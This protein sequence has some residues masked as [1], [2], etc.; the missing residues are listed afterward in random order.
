MVNPALLAVAFLL[1][2]TTGSAQIVRLVGSANQ[3]AGRL[4]VYYNDTWGTVCDDIF[5]S[6]AARVVCY[7]LGY[8]YVGEFVGN[9]Y[10]RGSGPIWLDN[11][12]CR[13]TETSIVNCPRNGWGIHNC[14]HGEDVSVSCT[15][16]R[17]AG[18]STQAGRL[19]VA[20]HNGTWG[21]VCDDG[22]TDEAAAVA[23][24]MLG[25]GYGGQFV[26]NRYG[27]GSGII[28][29]DDVQCTGTETSIA[30]CRHGGWGR[31]D[32]SHYEDV[33]VSC[34]TVRLTSGQEG[35]LEVYYNRTWGTVCDNGFTDA[36]A[37]VVCNMLGY[38]RIGRFI[39]N[40]YGAGY[41]RRI[42]LDN[43]RCSG[44]ETNIASCQHRGWGSYSCQHHQDVSVSCYDEVRLVGD[45]GSKGR[46][47][48][49]HNGAWGTV[50]DTGFTDTAAR[51]VCYSLGYGYT[52]RFLGNLY[53][54]GSGR[55]WL[56]NV[57]CYG[58]YSHILR[59]QHS[60]WGHHN[61][62]HSND[63]SV[64]CIA[65]ST[66]AVALVGGGSPRVGR[67][68]VF[69]G[70]QWG[71]VCDQGFTDAAARVVC[72]SLGFGYVGR[73]VDINIYGM[74]DGL[75]WLNNINCIGTEQYIGACSHRDPREG[76]LEVF[77]NGTW[78]SVCRD[79]FSDA[80]AKVVCNMLGFG[81]IGRPSSSY[82]SGGNGPTWLR[83]V[84]C[85]GTE[86][87]ISECRFEGWGVQNCY[88]TRQAVSCL[89][90]DAVALFGGGSPREGRL[91]VYHNGTWE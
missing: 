61:C 80:A 21:T 58:H 43:V 70:N 28:W 2:S 76:C 26:G 62:S 67:L 77:Y 59:C 75:I 19:E 78:G 40:R 7:M 37:R 41:G 39:G 38:Q 85:S 3:R 30:H 54:A 35:R 24:Y 45:S 83:S 90:D 71:T 14:V 89:P 56:D 73:K 44:T 57:R 60:Y 15:T 79:G 64:S 82:Y 23:C 33:S 88:F 49:Y 87:S 53:G 81:Y 32:C 69:H 18:G 48:V 63:V 72:Y 6:A 10:G 36:A 8:G 91:E 66:E 50:C 17:F 52:G 47:E 34:I 65:D 42:W 68:E 51:V 13:G 27:S 4:E 11:I 22:F 25:Y 55:I 31:H 86:E 5:T 29:L 46:L 16:A 12:Y 74:G 1:L 84:Q 9:R 20:Y